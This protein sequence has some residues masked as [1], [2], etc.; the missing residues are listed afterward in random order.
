VLDRRL[1]DI[2]VQDLLDHEGCVPWLYCDSKGF[3]TI[4]VG[5]LVKTGGDAVRLPLFR[6]ATGVPAIAEEKRNAHARVLQFYKPTLTANAYR[7]VT[8]LRITKEFALDLVKSRLRNEFLPALYKL[9]HDFD[10]WP[11]GAK[12]GAIDIIFNV[13]VHGISRFV[14]FVDACQ[15]QDWAMAKAHCT[16]TAARRP[17]TDKDP[18]GLGPRNRWTL[19][20]FQEAREER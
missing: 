7:A 17:P 14:N 5:N 1:E 8:D 13:G 10:S 19:A 20:R 6:M 4:G 2:V 11:E 9:F 16:R 3:V 12:R 18:E 15:R